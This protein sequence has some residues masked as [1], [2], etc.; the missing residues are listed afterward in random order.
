[1]ASESEIAR[2]EQPDS[3]QGRLDVMRGDEKIGQVWDG[4]APIVNSDAEC[5]ASL[6]RMASELPLT[7]KQQQLIQRCMDV[8]NSEEGDEFVFGIREIL[9]LSKLA[10]AFPEHSEIL[11]ACSHHITAS[12]EFGT[13]EV[14]DN[15]FA[16]MAKLYGTMGNIFMP[17]ENSEEDSEEDTPFSDDDATPISTAPSE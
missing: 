7:P 11:I 15:F 6:Q 9:G 4:V 13:E 16:I 17:G 5:V 2:E 1:M 12:L 3:V 8:I 14:P 10:L